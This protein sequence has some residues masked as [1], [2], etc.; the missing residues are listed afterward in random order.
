MILQQFLQQVIWLLISLPYENFSRPAR[1]HHSIFEASR[2]FRLYANEVWFLESNFKIFRAEKSNN[3][4]IYLQAFS[5]K[6]GRRG[7]LSY[8]LNLLIKQLVDLVFKLD[9]TGMASVSYLPE[10]I[11]QA[12]EGNPTD[13]K[14]FDELVISLPA[15]ES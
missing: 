2:E 11:H 7:G 15:Q 9:R 3:R 14:I 4:L 1:S 5:C 8:Y 10:F 12:D 6:W 13:T